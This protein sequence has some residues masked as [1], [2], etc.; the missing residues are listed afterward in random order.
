MGA[1]FYLLF[2]LNPA[3]KGWR[4]KAKGE[5][6]PKFCRALRAGQFPRDAREDAPNKAK[7]R[8]SCLCALLA[9]ATQVK[10]N[11]KGNGE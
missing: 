3:T 2:A 9:C 7:T 1:G 5:V 11:L 4:C 6:L 10:P 8:V